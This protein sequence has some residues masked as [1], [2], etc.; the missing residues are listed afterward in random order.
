M[1]LLV[2]RNKFTIF[3]REKEIFE[4]ETSPQPLS[5]GEGLVTREAIAETTSG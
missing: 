2:Y 5:K 3:Y 1:N 4:P